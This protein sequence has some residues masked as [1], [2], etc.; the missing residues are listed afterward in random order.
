MTISMMGIDLAKENFQVFAVDKDKRCIFSR[1]YKRLAFVNYM[2]QCHP[3]EVFIEACGGSNFWARKLS[4]LGHKVKMI[5]PQHVRPFVG[6]QKNDQ[7]DA[8]AILEAGQRIDAKFVATKQL[9]QQDL[10]C[11]HRIRERCLRNRVSLSNQIRGLLLEYG[12]TIPVGANNFDR[13]LLPHLED[14]E[15]E[16]TPMAR[17]LLYE[18]Y[19]D[20]LYCKNR[21]QGLTQR[22][23]LQSK[24]NEICQKLE[25]EIKGVGPVVSTAFVATV[26]DPRV[27]NCGRELSSW[28]GL[29]PRQN[30]TGGRSR[31]MGITKNGDSYL[32]KLIIQGSRTRIQAA[33]K[34]QIK[35]EQ[36]KKILSMYEKKGFNKTA[37][38]IANKNARMMWAIMMK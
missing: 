12:I 22:I 23:E 17:E 35:N 38:A 4:Q 2:A 15:N 26:G 21:L 5:S 14:S 3:C 8:R 25:R 13:H 19:N 24:N 34:R 9:W 32:R 30:S 33:Q 18:L 7:N 27:F 36:D 1:K 31:L 28:L 6:H 20:Y 16:L 37:V 11:L 29:V 10:Q